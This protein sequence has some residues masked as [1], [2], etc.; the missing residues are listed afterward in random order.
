MDGDDESDERADGCSREGSAVSDSRLSIGTTAAESKGLSTSGK[1][2]TCEW[3]D[4]YGGLTI[5]VQSKLIANPAGSLS[6]DHLPRWYT[7]VC[8]LVRSLTYVTGTVGEL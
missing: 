4:W 1:R 5:Q 8:I 6:V 2:W 7:T 3:P